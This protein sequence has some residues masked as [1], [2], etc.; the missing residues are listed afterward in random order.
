MSLIP[1]AAQLI[2]RA[3]TDENYAM[4]LDASIGTDEGAFAG[5]VH[6]QIDTDELRWLLPSEWLWFVRWRQSRGGSLQPA[7]LG[8]LESI[9]GSRAAR[10]QLR[11]LVMRDPTTERSARLHGETRPVESVGLTWLEEH[12]RTAAD[13]GEVARDALQVATE[14]A[15]FTLRVLTSL[16]DDRSTELRAQL[17][18]F[19]DLNGITSDITSRWTSNGEL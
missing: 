15:W 17:R 16:D 10:Y 12:A 11:Y 7:I 4:D 14:P 19:A 1:L 9:G 18:A 2:K 8:H 6:A 5:L 13:S 3:A